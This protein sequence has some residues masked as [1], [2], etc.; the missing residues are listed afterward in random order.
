MNIYMNISEHFP[1]HREDELDTA[2]I[3][4]SD[5]VTFYFNRC[6]IPFEENLV[7]EYED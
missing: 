5:D 3:V 4:F 6:S 1:I 7:N 2:C